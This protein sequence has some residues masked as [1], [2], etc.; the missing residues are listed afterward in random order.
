MVCNVPV[1]TGYLSALEANSCS[2]GKERL[3]GG[4]LQG[5]GFPRGGRWNYLALCLGIPC[6]EF[7][8]PDV[9]KPHK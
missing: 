9:A 2:G 7:F 5:E 1:L 8:C 3:I 6:E 4:G